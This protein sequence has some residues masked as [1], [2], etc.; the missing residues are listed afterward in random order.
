MKY[1]N[2]NILKLTGLHEYVCEFMF[3][4]VLCMHVRACVRVCVCVCV[5][6]SIVYCYLSVYAY[7]NV[8]M[9]H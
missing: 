1:M 8:K 4:Y 7:V 3:V 6:V 2:V 9:A 5:C